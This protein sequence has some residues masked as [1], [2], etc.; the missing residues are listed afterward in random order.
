MS[1]LLLVIDL[2]WLTFCSD[3]SS[4]TMT[5][6]GYFGTMAEITSKYTRGFSK[7][8]DYHTYG[9]FKQSAKLT[10]RQILPVG[11]IPVD[12]LGY[13]YLRC[14]GWWGDCSFRVWSKDMSLF[15]PL[16]CLETGERYIQLEA[17]CR[18]RSS[19]SPIWLDCSIR[20]YLNLAL[21]KQEKLKISSHNFLC[22]HKSTSNRYLFILLCENRRWHI[23]G[24][25][26]F[27]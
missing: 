8:S 20:V 23:F 5:V 7:L 27:S 13:K 19:I 11:V 12:F 15:F 16:Y 17:H 21:R 4:N 25:V 1:S 26:M 3:F 2:L 14:G 24:I 10:I 6:Y 22:L 9:R 18:I